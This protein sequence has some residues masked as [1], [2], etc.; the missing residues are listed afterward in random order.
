[1][2][3]IPNWADTEQIAPVSGVNL[4]RR[5]HGLEGRFLVM[6]SGNLGLTQRLS[7]FV[8]AAAQLRDDARIHFAFV[9][10]GSLEAELRAQVASLRLEN[11]SF[12][13]YQAREGL[14]DSLSAADL[15]LVPLTAALAGCLMPSKLYGILAAGRPCL[16]NAPVGT[17]LQRLVVEEG[18]GFSVPCGTVEQL[19]TAIREAASNPERLQGMNLRSRK[20]A[21]T[22][23]RRE[24]SVERFGKLLDEVLQ[25]AV[26]C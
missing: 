3:V 22:R 2:A 23:F 15:H 12:F 11:V 17:E 20:L 25:S 8:E 26:K 21:E 16:T 14:S 4:F 24:L 6:Y 10:R 13:D 19:A 1:V 9:G 7:D 5:Q 18:I